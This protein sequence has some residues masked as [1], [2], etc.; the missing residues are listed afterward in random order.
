M[1][2]SEQLKLSE[3]IKN[4]HQNLRQHS[5]TYGTE[6]AWKQHVKN[7]DQ[8]KKYAQCM[9]TLANQFWE[10]NIRKRNSAATQYCRIQWAI[11]QCNEYFFDTGLMYQRRREIDIIHK[12]AVHL[13]KID[14]SEPEN[15]N[16]VVILDVGSCFN[17]LKSI[18][19]FEVIAI[20]LC[21]AN[22]FVKK[23]D[24]LEVKCLDHVD[25]PSLKTGSE[26]TELPKEHFNVVLFSLLLEYLPSNEQRILCCKKAYQLLKPEGILIIITPDSKHVGANAQLMKAWRYTLAG[27]GFMRIK[28]EKL[29]HLHCIVFRKC[30]FKPTADRW[31]DLHKADGFDRNQ[32]N[33]PQDA[34]IYNNVEKNIEPNPK[35]VKI[36]KTSKSKCETFLNLL[37]PQ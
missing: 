20:D 15:C 7:I 18:T 9:D 37:P 32:I 5:Q 33:I 16:E 34:K 28:Y 22:A 6:N 1:A 36:D 19:N 4:V 3:F 35:R 31:V 29:T 11:K 30:L 26:I 17:P 25:I 21:P 10:P 23:C 14:I 24:F 27:L 2:T 12:L 8:L 13:T